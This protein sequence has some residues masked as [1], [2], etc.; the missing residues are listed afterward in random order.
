M[1]FRTLFH[2]ITSRFG[3]RLGVYDVARTRFRVLPTDL[4]VL[5]HMNNGVYFSIAD[6]ARFDLLIRGGVWAEFQRRKWYSVVANETI[7]FRKSLMP[8]QAFTIES[9]IIGFDAKAVYMEQRFVVRSEVY[10]KAFIRARFLRTSGGIVPMDEVLDAVGRPTT[11]LTVPEWLL[12]WGEESA[13]PST[14][15]DAVS[16]WS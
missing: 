4:D 11:E 10:A 8:W 9:R 6:V 3:P 16:V 1:I 14:R 7:T 13:L 5:R 2:M 15:A 12:S